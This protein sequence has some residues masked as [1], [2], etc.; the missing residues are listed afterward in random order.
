MDAILGEE[1]RLVRRPS[2]FG[3]HVSEHFGEQFRRFVTQGVSPF[4]VTPTA[5]PTPITAIEVLAAMTKLSNNK[6]SRYDRIPGELLKHAT[7]CLANS[8][9]E[10]FSDALEND[11]LPRGVLI[12]L[13]NPG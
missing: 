10:I 2:E 3:A 6:A 11:E 1:G 7:R 4:E 12:L 9:E 13:H 5:L 8:I